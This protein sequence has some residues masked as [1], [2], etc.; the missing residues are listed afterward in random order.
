[1]SEKKMYG[2]SLKGMRATLGDTLVEIG[3]KQ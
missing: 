2:A 1:M 3:R